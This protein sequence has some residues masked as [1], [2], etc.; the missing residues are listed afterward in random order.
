MEWV[1]SASLAEVFEK[2]ESTIKR[3]VREFGLPYLTDDKGGYKLRPNAQEE[4]IK[5]L[6]ASKD[7]RKERRETKLTEARK[8]KEAKIGAERA[9][10]R[11][12]KARAAAIK[13]LEKKPVK[14]KT[15]AGQSSG[16]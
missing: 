2:K 14:P 16:A 10:A 5:F 4:L 9:K 15:K 12:E 1:T 13:R 11:S 8:R 6:F 7:T 3:W